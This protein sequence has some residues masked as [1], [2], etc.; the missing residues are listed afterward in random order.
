MQF[1]DLVYASKQRIM[2]LALSSEINVLTSMLRHI[3]ERDRHYRD[4]TISSIAKMTSV[5][6]S[7][8]TI[9]WWPS[10]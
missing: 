6:N 9:S 4:F 3:S 8:T 2:R 7:G 10:S 5:E 1:D